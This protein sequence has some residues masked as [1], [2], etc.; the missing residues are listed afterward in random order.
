MF[1][2]YF[3]QVA[4][5][6]IRSLQPTKTL[7]I[8]QWC[9]PGTLGPR[10]CTIFWSYFVWRAAKPRTAPETCRFLHYCRNVDKCSLVYLDCWGATWSCFRSGSYSSIFCNGECKLRHWEQ[11]LDQVSGP[12]VCLRDSVPTGSLKSSILIKYQVRMYV[13]T[14][15]TYIIMYAANVFHN[16]LTTTTQIFRQRLRRVNQQKTTRVVADAN[17]SKTCRDWQVCTRNGDFVSF[18]DVSFCDF[19]WFGFSTSS[20]LFCTRLP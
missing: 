10:T 3:Q 16:Y 7:L 5:V 20:V 14:Y 1:R 9:D 15:G 6:W 11:P 4:G 18:L 13:C 8:L 19:G 2:F 17:V 12:V